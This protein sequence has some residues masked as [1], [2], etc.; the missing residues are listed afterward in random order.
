MNM[1]KEI[2][3]GVWPA[4][5]T[6]LDE[7]RQPSEENITK[8]VELF[9]S[10]KVGGL[11]V[12]GSTGQG[13]AMSVPLRKEVMELTS[14]ANAGRLPI[15]THVGAVSPHD[16]IE[17]AK[18]AQDNGADAISSVPPIYFPPNAEIMFNHYNVIA[19]ATK[20]P[21][22][23]YHLQTPGLPA[24]NDYVKMLLDIPN[25]KGMKITDNNLFIVE[26]VVAYAKGRLQIFSGCDELILPGVMAGADGAIGSFYNFFAPQVIKARQTLLD[27]DIEAGRH[28]MLT[29]S[30]IIFELIADY[31]SV[32]PFFQSAMR[33]KYGID[34][35]PGITSTSL[36]KR[37]LDDAKVL[38]TFD[39]LDK[40]AGLS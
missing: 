27:G 9:V 4:V 26:M 38:A 18:H 17:L 32:Y 16:S 31:G 33:L 10:Q 23:P 36:I 28:F 6:C 1:A 8:I 7:N 19:S 14:K 5:L 37:Q 20:L 11:Y 35:G 24:L 21:F 34:I 39:E 13:P 15:M 12:L 30:R 3:G 22:Y 25:I 2:A 29:F 40:A